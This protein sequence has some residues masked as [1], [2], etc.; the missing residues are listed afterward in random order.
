M[1]DVPKLLWGIGQ[2]VVAKFIM[3]WPN[4][5][6]QLIKV[7]ATIK[8]CLLCVDL[9]EPGNSLNTFLNSYLILQLLSSYDVPKF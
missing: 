5:L 3:T 6:R 1:I 9:R 8:T 2:H 7:P 4:V